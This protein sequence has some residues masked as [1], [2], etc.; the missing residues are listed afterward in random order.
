MRGT[1]HGLLAA[2]TLSAAG[3][4]V[5]QTFSG[6][7][8]EHAPWW[9]VFLATVAGPAVT[10]A[11]GLFVRATL[12]ACAAAL[13]AASQGRGLRGMAGAAAASLDAYLNTSPPLALPPAEE[14][15]S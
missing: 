11:G 7:G 15:K 9:A 6:S 10:Y 1:R 14:R 4:S 13:H 12:G 2:I 8:M 3:P 5:A